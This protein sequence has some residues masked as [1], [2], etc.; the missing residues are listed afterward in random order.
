MILRNPL[1]LTMLQRIV[2]Q[3]RWRL[4]VAIYLGH[5]LATWVLLFLCNEPIAGNVYDYIYFYV[6]SS[7]TIGFGDLSPVTNAGKLVFALLIAPMGIALFAVLLA[8]LGELYFILRK[9][10][11]TGEIEIHHCQDHVVIFGWQADRTPKLIDLIHAEDK[12][13]V[14]VSDEE[15]LEHPL[16][17][18]E[19][20]Y[21]NVGSYITEKALQRLSLDTCTSV[22]IN[23]GDDAKNYLACVAVDQYLKKIQA[24]AHI[25]VYA[26]NEDIQALLESTSR[27]IEVIYVHKEHLLSRSAL[28]AGSSSCS[29]ALLNPYISATQYTLQ[30]PGEINPVEFQQLSGLLRQHFGVIAI[31]ISDKDDKLGRNLVL[32]PVDSVQLKAGDYV[33][34]IANTPIDLTHSK[35]EN[36]LCSTN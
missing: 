3:T 33:H 17:D 11:L 1:L 26:D 29:E 10:I 25:V 5:F 23:T 2:G 36:L 14:I 22:V 13:V 4:L 32:N 20:R 35:F 21:V 34:Y 15:G 9:K 7:S 28:F 19:T 6:V 30:L 24:D 16:V 18:T 27:K 31:G 12:Q 8:K